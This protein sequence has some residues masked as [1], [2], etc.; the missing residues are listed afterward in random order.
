VVSVVAYSLA[1]DLEEEMARQ[2]WRRNPNQKMIGLRFSNVAEPSD[3]TK[4]P[5]FEDNPASR[6]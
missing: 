6:K 2:Y 1:K 5:S 3:Y 4:F